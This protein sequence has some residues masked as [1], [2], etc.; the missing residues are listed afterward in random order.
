LLAISLTT[1][2]HLARDNTRRYTVDE[3]NRRAS[4]NARYINIRDV[5]HKKEKSPSEM[6]V[7]I[8]RTGE[9]CPLDEKSAEDVS[10]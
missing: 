7:S 3:G 1:M 2:D 6:S 5:L 8:S 10:M 9:T 4:E